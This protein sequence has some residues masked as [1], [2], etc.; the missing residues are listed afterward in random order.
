MSCFL[1]SYFSL[2]IMFAAVCCSELISLKTTSFVNILLIQGGPE[3]TEMHTSR[4]MWM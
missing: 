2:W 1:K 3:K 4:N